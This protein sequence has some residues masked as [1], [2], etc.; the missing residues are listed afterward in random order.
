TWIVTSSTWKLAVSGTAR[1]QPPRSLLPRTAVI[2]ASARSA[3]SI[4]GVPMS[5]ACTMWSLPR[6]Y[7]SAS[8]RSSPCVSEIS[9][10]RATS[11]ERL[12]QI[13]RERR[14]H[15]VEADADPFFVARA[16]RDG[17]LEIRRKDQQRAVGHVDH[18]LV[19]ILRGQLDHRR[20]DDCGLGPG[21]VEVDAVRARVRP[22]V[23]HAAQK[24]VGMA[25]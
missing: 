16:G 11:P 15:D 10:T 20:P 6:R 14:K 3:S 22:H 13:F 25:V 4:S 18:H 21:V 17:V 5:P 19:G 9:P 2:G 8:G 1:A 23:I 7:A 12:A 24:I